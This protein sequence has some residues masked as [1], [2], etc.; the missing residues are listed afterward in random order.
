MQAERDK[1]AVAKLTAVHQL[2]PYYGVR[3][4]SMA[5]NWSEK[6]ARRIRNLAGVTP[7]KR[8]KKHRTRSKKPEIDAP[9][10]ALASYIEYVNP[11]KPWEG[12]SFNKMAKTSG[13]WVQDFSYINYHGQWV[14]LATVEELS[15][16]RILGWS[17]GLRHSAELVHDALL[18]A[19]SD[20]VAPPILHDDQGSEY[21]S[22]LMQ[23]TCRRYNIRLSCSDK[24]S[25][26]QNGFKEG[27]FSTFKGEFGNPNR[28]STLEELYEAIAGAIYY[29]NH[30][31]I[32]TALRTSPIKYAE[33]LT[34]TG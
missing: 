21:L 30:E 28:F 10:N 17:V 14:Y 7:M 25:P 29:Y 1:V 4:F 5:L 2:N 6:K 34:L 18:D 22:Y 3:R 23:D 16:R 32:H 11:E 13:A 33:Q 24:A 26:W 27:A 15:T 9:D 19:L 8:Y 12:S 20:N 31:R